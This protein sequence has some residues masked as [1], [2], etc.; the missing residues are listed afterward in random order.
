MAWRR[1]IWVGDDGC[2]CGMG[3]SDPSASLGMT[4]KGLGMTKK[5]ARDDGEGVKGMTDGFRI[6]VRKDEVGIGPD[7]GEFP[8]RHARFPSRSNPGPST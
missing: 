5:R 3:G 7:S 8:I 4:K 2:G 6:G 1:S